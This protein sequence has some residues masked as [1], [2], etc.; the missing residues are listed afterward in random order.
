[1]R[2]EPFILLACAAFAPGA[3]AQAQADIAYNGKWSANIVAEG[4]RHQTAQLQLREFSGTWIGKVGSADKAKKPCKGTKFPVTV[5]T[6]NDTNLDFTVWG[7]MVS[8]ACK[9]LTIELQPTGKDVFEGTVESL[10]TIT[11]ARH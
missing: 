9:D 5:Q 8:P 2:I 6:S 10:G 11:L 7:S 4:G 1:M 3:L